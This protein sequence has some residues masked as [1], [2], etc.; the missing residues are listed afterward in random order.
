MKKRIHTSLAGL[1]L[2]GTIVLSVSLS[3]AEEVKTFEVRA[4]NYKFSPDVIAANRGDTVII[5]AIAIDKNHGFGINR[6]NVNKP[7]PKE[8]WVT[9]EFTADRS[10]EFTIRCTKFC[11][12]KH[13]W[14]K[15]KLIVK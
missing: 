2:I 1:L 5:K 10:G 12:W 4:E 7:L 11:G 15:G 9:I 6:F 3:K 13:F 14:M 8:E